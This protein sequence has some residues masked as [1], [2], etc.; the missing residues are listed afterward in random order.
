MPYV[1]LLYRPSVR[2]AELPPPSIL[3]AEGLATVQPAVGAQTRNHDREELECPLRLQVIS[4]DYSETVKTAAQH[5][6]PILEC[7][8]IKSHMSQTLPENLLKS[9]E[10]A[11][12]DSIVSAGTPEGSYS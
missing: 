10:I 6:K 7:T 11:H 4:S 9:Q 2:A 8:E 1:G 5:A 3:Q 12:K